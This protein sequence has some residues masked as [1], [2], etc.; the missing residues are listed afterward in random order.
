MIFKFLTLIEFY[1]KLKNKMY[2]IMAEILSS[3]T[4]IRWGEGGGGELHILAHLPW[5]INFFFTTESAPLA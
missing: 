3:S 5:Q 1:L 4:L 2:H